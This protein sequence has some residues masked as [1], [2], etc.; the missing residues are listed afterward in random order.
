MVNPTG[1]SSDGEIELTEPATATANGV[2]LTFGTA[3]NTNSFTGNTT[4]TAGTYYDVYTGTLISGNSTITSSGSVNGEGYGPLVTETNTA[5]V[6]V[7][8]PIAISNAGPLEISASAL[9]NG[10]T[11]TG[12]SITIADLGPTPLTIS[13]NLVLEATGAIVFLDPNNTIVSTGNISITAGNVAALGNLATDGSDVTIIAGGN[14]GVGT[15]NAG[16]GT[17]TIT[18][19]GSIFNNHGGSLAITAGNTL[20][21]QAKVQ[22]VAQGNSPG[23]G[24]NTGSPPN[25]AQ[26]QLNAAQAIATAA[27]DRAQ[28]AADQ[29]TANAFQAELNSIQTTVANDQN[30]YQAD[31]T[32]TNIAN[33]T[34]NS[35][36]GTVNSET[37]KENNLSLASAISF[38]S[39]ATLDL[40]GTSTKETELSVALLGGLAGPEEAL[41]FEAGDTPL[42]V[43]SA[44]LNEASAATALAAAGLSYTLTN[45]S[46]SLADDEATAATDQSDQ[47]VALSRLQADLDTET[48]VAAAYNVAEQAAASEAIT[49]KQDQ[50]VSQADSALV[51]AASAQ[52]QAASA[53]ASAANVASTATAQPLSV[54]GPLTIT[55]EAP[56]SGNSNTGLAISAPITV[57]TSPGG[58]TLAGLTLN[59]N[60]S[61]LSVSANISAPGPIALQ[62]P[63]S[64]A[65]GGDLTVN[66]GVTI[67]SNSAISLSATGNVGTGAGSGATVTVNGTLGAPSATI[68]A[69][70]GNDTF[71]ITPSATTPITVNGGAGSD[72]LNF[73]ADG[74]AVTISGNKITA[75]TLKPVTFTNI[76][77]VNIT[78]EAGG[79]LT[80]NGT[81]GAANAMSLVG[82][83]Q[84]AGTA[85]LNGIPFSFSG[86][87]SFSYQG[88]AGD[89]IAV[90][91]FANS[92]LPWNLA[93]T[94]SGGSGSTT[95]LTYNAAG[96]ADT[97]TAT[98]KNAG[99]VA[100]PGV[101]TVLVSN[102][103]QVTIAYQGLQDVEILPN[104]TVSDTGGSYNGKAFSATVQVN[105]AASL[106]GITPTLTY[107]GG[108]IISPA[109]RLSGVPLNAGAYTAV[110][111]FAGDATYSSAS[112]LTTFII[113][114][115]TPQVSVKPVT[116]TFG[117]P[118]A[119]GQLSGTAT[120]LVNGTKVNLPGVFS[121][122]TAAGTKLPASPTAY[123]EQVTFT[124]NSISYAPL[125]NLT[126]MVTV[127]TLVMAAATT[128]GPSTEVRVTYSNGTSDTWEPFGSQFTAGATVA[129]GDVTG[130]GYPDIVVASGDSGKAGTVQVY[131]GVTR[132][133]I[134]SYMP[135][136]T[137]GGGLDVAVGDLAG[138]G[139][140]D[141]VVS[142]LGGG[143]PLVTVL[144][145][146]TGNLIDQFLAYSTSFGGG[147]RVGVGDISGDGYADVVVGPGAG[148]HG[149]PVE[150]YS[151]QSIMT[152]T[153]TPQ[154]LASFTPFASS[155][156]GA[157]DV[158]VGDLTS[159]SYADIVVGTQCSGEQIK[160]YS[161]EAL[162]PTSPP[163]PLFTQNVWATTDNSGV[164]VAL[165]PDAAGDGFDDLIVTNGTGSKT[166]R[167]LDAEL[168]AN[169]WPTSDA[170]FFIAIPGVTSGVYVG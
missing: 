159:T 164:K 126:V 55:G 42:D 124:P 128:A 143:Y 13:S 57:S 32:A 14:I 140:D 64:A 149:L 153:G 98:G 107:Y 152:G 160:V 69:D 97:V 81:A 16:T 49:A 134:A 19:P 116:L 78:N 125:T 110:A 129:L 112:A 47:D 111:A 132:A 17:V 34:A 25:L 148:Q 150:V 15:L 100:E 119:N 60:G 145:G 31:V 20:L 38:V 40:L 77:D 58:S 161:G 103:G 101:A 39:A 80:L 6:A 155:Y 85:T 108:N 4:G 104:L 114:S 44:V 170:E 1:F 102:V 113:T 87:T 95:S 90:T 131:N 165:V 142:V 12:S 162:S 133:L 56:Q 75:G 36:Q 62:A 73:N 146:A 122:T 67:Q 8:A 84:E 61:S 156:A 7:F 35:E 163:T 106:D 3:P 11:F 68:N 136:G 115:G 72:T 96:P 76:E 120:V 70:Q 28:A 48:A 26:L 141:I 130:D 53:Q 51:Q 65:G 169:G 121:Y 74:L 147:V 91:P 127:P 23:N 71:T 30:A 117:T 5:E 66:S 168:K 144:N 43:A 24:S 10:G 166:A 33:N 137:F 89:T 54:T 109:H 93:V 29:T 118:L 45:D 88:G 46:K 82:T 167:Y 21:Y 27:A 138:S 135:L 2:S 9:A 99:S 158:A 52:A 37:N 105:G 157:V 92:N 139:G 83:G 123:S 63:A 154:L 86:L 151:G 50:A 41:A 59:G 79:S 18:S 94:V 22:I